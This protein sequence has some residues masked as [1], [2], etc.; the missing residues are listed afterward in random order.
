MEKPVLVKYLGVPVRGPG[1]IKLDQLQSADAGVE[2]VLE[3]SRAVGADCNQ[4]NIPHLTLPFQWLL[5]KQK[6]KKL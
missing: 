4:Q 3:T 2:A 5:K 6:K 1:G